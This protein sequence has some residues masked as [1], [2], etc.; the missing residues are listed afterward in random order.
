MNHHLVRFLQERDQPVDMTRGRPYHK[1]DTAHVEQKNY[2]HVRALLGY[3]RIEDPSLLGPINDLY[4]NWDLY[5]NLW[6]PSL[7]LIEKVK[8]GSHY[9]KRYDTPKTP[10]QRLM[11]SP[12]VSEAM[13]THLTALLANTNPFQL[14]QRIQKMRDEIL[15][16]CR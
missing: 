5:N 10:Y 15:S 4:Q 14:D 2:T 16:K 3:Q 6:I 7:K 13:K 12:D 8:I 11:E 1:D 9:I